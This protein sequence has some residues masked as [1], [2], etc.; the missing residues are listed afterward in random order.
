MTPRYLEDQLQ[1]SLRNMDLDCVDVTTC[2]ILS[3]S[4]QPFPAKSFGGVC[5]RHL[6]FSS[7][8]VAQGKFETMVSRHGMGSG[9]RPDARGYHSLEQMVEVARDIAGD[10]H[11]FRFIQ[12]PV[13]LAMPEALFFPNQKVGDEWMTVTDAAHKL[14]VT[15]I[16]SGSICRARSRADCRKRFARRWV[17]LPRTR[18]P[19]FNLCAQRRES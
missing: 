16:A 6:S 5:G 18:R 3:R 10:P 9:S 2:T 14:G 8:S 4:C 1:Q 19:V 7:K 15:V 11:H 17:R 13:N 12:L